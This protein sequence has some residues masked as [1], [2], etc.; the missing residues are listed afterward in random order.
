MDSVENLWWGY[1]H[2]RGTVQAKR[3]YD[4][5]DLQE[6]RE[7]PFCQKVIGPFEAENREQALKTVIAHAQAKEKD[8]G[9]DS[10]N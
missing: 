8:N 7:S 10:S 9:K 2:V 1:I 4:P 6:A 5:L 3:Y